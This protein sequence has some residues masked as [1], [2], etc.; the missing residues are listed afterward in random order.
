MKAL[1]NS[2]T[3]KGRQPRRRLGEVKQSTVREMGCWSKQEQTKLKIA[4][5]MRALNYGK[6][7]N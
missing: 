4:A 7:E 5:A 6:H 3:G 1:Y 2:T